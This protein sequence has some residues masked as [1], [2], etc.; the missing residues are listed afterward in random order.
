MPLCFG[1]LGSVLDHHLLRQIPGKVLVIWDGL[2]AH[3][4]NEVK[5]FLT[6]HAANRLWLIRLPAYAPELNPIELAFSKL[7]FLLRKAAARTVYAL[8]KTIGK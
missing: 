4:S 1:A 6:D 8:W 7:K 5:R 3:R 2:P